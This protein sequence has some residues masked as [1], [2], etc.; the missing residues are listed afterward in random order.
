MPRVVSLLAIVAIAV[1]V[2]AAEVLFPAP[3]HLTRELTDP[4]SGTTSVI[5][6]YCHGNR[7]VAVSGPRTSIAEYDKGLLTVIDFENGTYSVTKFEELAKAWERGG[8]GRRE[9]IALTAEPEWRVEQREARVVASRAGETI[10]IRPDRHV[11]LSRAAAE[12]L[13]GLAWPNRPQ[14]S[15]SVVLNALKDGEKSDYALPLEQIREQNLDG[16][17]VTLRSVIVRVGSEFAPAEVQTVPAGAKLIEAKDVAARRLLDE[18]DRL[19][20]Q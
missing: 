1:S 8:P 13:A 2:S 17:T 4:I 18:L 20:S 11:K 15:A 6:E 16:D 5:E 3:L 19:P 7:V 10:R 9:E 14:A 12:V